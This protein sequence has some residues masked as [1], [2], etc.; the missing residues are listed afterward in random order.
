MKTVPF[1]C[2]GCTWYLCLNAAALFDL[3]D[4]FG[5]KGGLA[6]PILKPGRPGFEAVCDFLRILAAHGELVRRWQGMDRGR[7]P[8]E[9][10]FSIALRPADYPEAKRA[11]LRAIELGFQREEGGQ[12]SVD[13][14]LLE[15]ER[16]EGTGAT[17]SK[18]L[19]LLTQF[20]HLPPRE[21]MLMT[22]GQVADLRALEERRRGI[23]KEG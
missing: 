23:R 5:D 20:L 2:G 9:Q 11:I 6:D 18:F 7:L 16:Q 1:E 14:G 15:L 19:Q 8:G 22:P 17:R 12:E 13:L 21:G 3:Y 10:T 4:K